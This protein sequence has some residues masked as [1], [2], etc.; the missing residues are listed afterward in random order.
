MVEL[1][2]SI[3]IFSIALTAVSA[4]YV[5]GQKAA[6]NASI[7]AELRQ[8][9]RVAMDRISREIRQARVIVTELPSDEED[10]VSELI[11]QNGHDGAT[12]SYIRYFLDGTDLRRQSIVYTF[13]VEP[14]VYVPYNSRDIFDNSP[15]GSVTAD[16]LVGEFFSGLSFWG[17]LPLVTID[18][19][20][21]NQTHTLPLRTA[22]YGRN[23]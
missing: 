12:T 21:T 11:F 23:L 19:S 15:T 4:V 9:A 8:N 18:M 1:L 14:S 13:S 20:L 5:Q 7:N 3:A 6:T 17:L 22:V 10:A 2:V 16:E